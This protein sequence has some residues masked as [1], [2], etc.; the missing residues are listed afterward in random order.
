LRHL[1]TGW[2]PDAKD[3]NVDH[4][5]EDENAPSEYG[6]I[7]LVVNDEGSAVEDDLEE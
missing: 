4:T 6:G 1:K 7:L 5:N 3:G 2:Y